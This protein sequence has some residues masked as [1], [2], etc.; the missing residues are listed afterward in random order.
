LSEDGPT[1]GG[2]LASA[3]ERLAAAGIAPARV[4][5][6]WLLAG[7]LGVRRF[8]LLGRYADR[9]DGPVAA[10]CE[11]AIRRRAAGE[12]MQQIVGWEAFRGLRLAVTPDVLVPRPETEALVEWALALLPAA[13]PPLVIDV[14]TG[15]GAIACAVASE[16][17]GSRVVAID[18]SPAAAAV[19]RANA[20]AL[21]LGRRVAVIVADLVAAAR[22]G[23]ADLVVA[24]PPYLTAQMLA[25]AR[26]EV[27]EHEPRLALDGGPDGLAV[28]GPLVAGAR[29]VLRP[30]ASLVVE[31]AGPVHVDRVAALMREAGYT[32]V[33][34]REDLAG[35]P[36]FVA[37]RASGAGGA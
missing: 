21:G 24:N 16:R 15:S 8:D 11:T 13:P 5:A 7:V 10:R 6:E 20:A 26:P 19:A 12:P 25:G 4:E 36:R 31:T 17:P 14:G 1:V 32:A 37:G 9:L 30:G 2:C 18:L 33:A 23:S 34:V 3:A 28:L 29:R 22:A 35:V 27:R